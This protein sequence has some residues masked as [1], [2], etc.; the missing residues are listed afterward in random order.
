MFVGNLG[1]YYTSGA[2]RQPSTVDLHHVASCSSGS[3]CEHLRAPE[4]TC[5]HLLCHGGRK[6][7]MLPVGSS[8]GTVSDVLHL[9]LCIE[10]CVKLEISTSACRILIDDVVTHCVRS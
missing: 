3:S 5:G 2:S 4:G 6:K 9:R 7:M 1:C 8:H 10:L